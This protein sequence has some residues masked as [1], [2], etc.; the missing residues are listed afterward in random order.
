MMDLNIREIKRSEY[1]LVVEFTFH[2]MFAPPDEEPYD[3]SF[4]THPVVLPYHENFGAEKS[5]FAVVA[6][7]DGV[8]VG[9]AWMRVIPIY[10]EVDFDRPVLS[11]AVLPDYRG[12]KI[13]T[14]LLDSIL[15]LLRKNG[16][17]GSL[18]TVHDKHPTR[19]LYERA[20][21][22]YVKLTGREWL[23]SLE[24]AKVLG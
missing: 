22:E 6:E 7:V 10:D 13:G 14:A 16:Y 8:I 9:M 15:E 1:P 11:L 18:L 19:S 23:M 20:G 5:D 3:R 21:Y 24:F 17:K 4:L 12:K 2:S